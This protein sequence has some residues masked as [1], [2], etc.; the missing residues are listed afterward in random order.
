MLVREQPFYACRLRRYPGTCDSNG[1]RPALHFCEVDLSTVAYHARE[2]FLFLSPRA[3]VVGLKDH[4][5]VCSNTYALPV[6]IDRFFYLSP[7][8]R[9]P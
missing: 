9:T 3:Q 2:R 7:I 1:T 6:R 4:T 5:V 8:S